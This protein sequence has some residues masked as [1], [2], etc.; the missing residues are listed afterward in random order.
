[1]K[2]KSFQALGKK[3]EIDSAVA[4]QSPSQELRRRKIGQINKKMENESR[5]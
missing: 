3:A 1:M 4:S 2:P 5:T